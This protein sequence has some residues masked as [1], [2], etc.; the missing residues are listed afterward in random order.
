MIRL[1]WSSVA[2]VAIAP[3]Q[4]VLSLGN[5][6]RMNLPGQPEG[7]W[8]W[9]YHPDALDPALSVRLAE[10]TSLYGRDLA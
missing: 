10:L 7:N 8:Q 2:A 5:E 3:L 6:G 9:R 1:A 4:D